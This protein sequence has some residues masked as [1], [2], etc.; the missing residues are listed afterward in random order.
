MT[1]T[2]ARTVT[3]PGEVEMP[4]LG[5]GTWQATGRQAYEAVLAALDARLPAHRHRHHVR[6]RGAGRPG[7]AGQRAAP[8]GRLHHHQT[9]AR[10]GRAA[11]ARRSRRA[12]ARSAPT[13]STCG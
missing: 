5:F 7:G 1:G 4:L 12:C 10:A 9:A 8:G 11:S 6:Q 3:L 13:T 2:V